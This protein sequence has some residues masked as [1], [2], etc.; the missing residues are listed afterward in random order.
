MSTKIETLELEIVTN[1]KSATKGLDS[2]AQSLTK[3]KNATKGGLGLSAVTKELN[4]LND[5]LKKTPDSNKKAGK[6]FTDLFHAMKSG[7]STISR[8][9]KTL[10]SF[11]NE[12]SS[13]TENVHL[14]NVAM[15][16]YADEAMSYAE[17]V[18]A[19]MGIDTND[20]I[21]SQG[22]FMTLATG[23]GV[24]SDR[25]EVMSRNLTQLG[26]DLSSFYNI[27]VEDAMQKLQSGLAGELE[28]L[29]RLGYDLSQAKL[30]ATALALGIDKSVS[31]MTQAE[32]AQLRYYA[33]L[34]QVTETHGDMAATL[35]SPA[36]QLRILKSEF[37]MAAREVGNA[38]IPALNA[39]L[40][41]AIAVTKVIGSM[42]SIIAGLFGYEAPEMGDVTSQMVENTDAISENMGDAQAEAKKLKSYMLGF[43]ELN[44][45]NPNSGGE[46]DSSGQFDFTLPEYK[47]MDESVSSAVNAIVEDMKEWL[48]I[49]EEITSWSEL[50]E[51]RLGK[52][53]LVVGS[54]AVA[55]LAWKVVMGIVGIISTISAGLSKI[56]SLFGKTGK[57]GAA[58]N[59]SANIDNASST[60]S[61]LTSKLKG[62]VKNLALGIVVILEVIVAV[63]LVV[64]AIWLL[65]ILL[66]EVANAWQPVLDNGDTVLTAVALG[67]VILVAIGVITA[68]LGSVG[69][70]LIA[71]LA[72]GIAMMALLG[73]S[74][75]LFL[76]EILIVGIMLNEIGIA[77]QPVLDNGDTIA[78]G[79][80]I[81]TA[82]LIAIGVV[83]A[84]LGVA[85]VATA[86]LLPLAIGL[87]TAMLVA[88]AAAFILFTESLIAVAYELSDRLHPALAEVNLVLPYLSSNMSAFTSFMGVFALEV[89]KYSASS[90]IAGIAATI[91]TILGFFTTD[92]V[93]KMSREIEDQ[94]EEFE[95]LIAGLEVILPN[96]DKA[97]QLVTEYNGAM[98]QFDN[99]SGGNKGLFGSLGL[100]KDGINGIL[101]GIEG[102]VNGVIRG[103]NF[104]INALNKISF[105]IPDW[106][107]LLGGKTFGLNL[108]TLNEISLP[109]FAEGG[110]PEQGQ[111]FVAREAGP[112]MVGSIGRRTAVANNEQIVAGI[113]GGVASANE[114]Q[115]VLL[116]EQ[117]SLLRA[118]LEKDS[119]VY[120]DGKNL[121]NSVEKYQRE[122]GRVL[123][124]G[125]VI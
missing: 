26:Y 14:F 89:V 33:I 78:T 71:S 94:N 16:E 120:L 27:D 81:G 9:S 80:A 97:T 5:G 55:F 69:A 1:S 121:T 77:W 7:V 19:A 61:E 43:D 83:A 74:A 57:G 35:D 24:A 39:I 73:V 31:S 119:G 72:L 37:G 84:L 75:A 25:A 64:G 22:V 46:D 86:G 93:E 30:E 10:M 104:M 92:P 112:E 99:V 85:T 96:I 42:A 65:G 48:G 95:D 34:T 45:I 32:K 6:S 18:R 106:V 70:S 13:Y 47:F 66:Q 101:A 108:K 54:I 51:T 68:V 110:F 56:A 114:E 111:M 63:G 122:R 102:L 117:N 91:D 20:W 107:P 52:I 76:A 36:N 38:F 60:F 12:S 4:K 103:I 79:I 40:P 105:T 98:G 3:I 123:I 59:A 2:L 8:L 11:I 100:I 17:S 29:R 113:A 90:T 87:G 49:T 21:R 50:L 58:G 28:P 116:R 118:I 53:L 15:G 23:F 124:T 125:G 67:T 115:N 62:L 88:L 82:L 109:R 41:Y 44:V